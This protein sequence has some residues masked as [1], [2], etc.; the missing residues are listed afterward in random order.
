MFNSQPPSWYPDP[1]SR[2][3]IDAARGAVLDALGGLR[4]L[5]K[6]SSSMRVG[7][8][9]LSSV[10]PD[11]LYSCESLRSGLEELFSAVEA[12]RLDAHGALE[13][14]RNFSRP[15]L[16]ELNDILSDSEKLPMQA[17]NRLKLQQAIGRIGRELGA[18]AELV[19]FLGLAIWS[20]PMTVT[21]QDLMLE[22]YRSNEPT[23]ELSELRMVHLQQ[24]PGEVE[25]HVKP[26]AVIPLLVLLVRV[27]LGQ[28]GAITPL[29]VLEPENLG[30]SRIV[31]SAKG[32]DGEPRWLLNRPVIPAAR[33]CLETAARALD[34]QLEISDDLDHMVAAFSVTPLDE[35]A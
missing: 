25:L 3:R 23:G 32:G 33:E 18:T 34:L 20:K 26:R 14:L 35:T 21:M 2:D 19:D 17:R 7:P 27:M 28:H 29:V 13:L 31:I 4:N 6:L 5:E 12:H 9:S 1:A 11:V 16:E 24:S 8:R 10:L 30:V 22:A 15:R